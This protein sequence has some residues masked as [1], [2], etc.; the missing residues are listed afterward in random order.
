MN[1]AIL[2]S[3]IKSFQHLAPENQRE[4][5]SSM[6]SSIYLEICN[7]RDYIIDALTTKQRKEWNG[8]PIS[9]YRV[10]KKAKLLA[11]A[12]HWIELTR[13]INELNSMYETVIFQII[14]KPLLVLAQ[15]ESYDWYQLTLKKLNNQVA[16]RVSVINQAGLRI[17]K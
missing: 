11:K 4:R 9:L 13:C 15:N 2:K 16:P 17:V 14:D 12:D 6:R 7:T 1:Y 5:L 3:D 8:S 10:T